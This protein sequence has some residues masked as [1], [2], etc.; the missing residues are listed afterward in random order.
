MEGYPARM[1]N[2]IALA[3]SDVDAGKV[4]TY[5][6][7]MRAQATAA[8]LSD[9]LPELIADVTATLRATI[10]TGNPLDVDPTKIPRSLRGLAVRM[11][12]RRIKDYL[13]TELSN[14]EI[15]QAEEDRSYLL[16]INDNKLRFELPDNAAVDSAEQT[17]APKPRISC[18]RKHFSRFEEDGI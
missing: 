8:G 13:E 2:W 15:K 11:V 5:L 6:V 9:P 1:S 18:R 3:E 4:N 16:R 14:A 17:P 12:V 10:S 7:Q